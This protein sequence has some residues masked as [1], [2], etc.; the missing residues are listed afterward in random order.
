MRILLSVL[1]IFIFSSAYTQDSLF[2]S[3]FTK[4]F[5]RAFSV[6]WYVYEDSCKNTT[7]LLKVE[8]SSNHQISSM[9]FSDNAP[10]WM[11]HE[12]EKVKGKLDTKEINNYARK[13][14]LK[15]L[16]II[17]PVIIE[18]KTSECG[19]KIY[20][21]PSY[22]VKHYYFKGKTLKGECLFLKPIEVFLLGINS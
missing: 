13:N 16:N 7:T 10:D 9:S 12:L 4:S 5:E 21:Y 11:I 17:F 15:K 18:N 8:I 6:P 22:N 19:G 20:N 14:R 1:F 2:L 3:S